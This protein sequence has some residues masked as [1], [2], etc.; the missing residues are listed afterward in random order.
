M[1][2]K[3]RIAISRP[4]SGASQHVKH[5]DF[6][7]LSGPDPHKLENTALRRPLR[8][9]RRLSHLQFRVA[10]LTAVRIAAKAQVA[11]TVMRSSTMRP[12]VKT[13]HRFGPLLLHSLGVRSIE[14]GFRLP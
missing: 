1:P 14:P 13:L 9:H 4:K 10:P 7:P 12:M 11:G 5:I 3:L 6:C 8:Q 2:K